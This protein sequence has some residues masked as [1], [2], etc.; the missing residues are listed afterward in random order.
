[1]PTRAVSTHADACNLFDIPDGGRTIRHKLDVLA[2]HCDALGRDYDTIDSRLEAGETANQFAD[3]CAT[4]AALG[5]THV[6]LITTGPWTSG[7][8]DVICSAARM[9]ETSAD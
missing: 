3:R 5:I 7:E 2:G 4:L 1:M 6:V 9:L 8:L